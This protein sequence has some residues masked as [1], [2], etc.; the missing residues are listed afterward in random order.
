MQQQQPARDPLLSMVGMHPALAV[1]G[2]TTAVFVL[3]VW[4]AAAADLQVALGIVGATGTVELAT[5]LVVLLFPVAAW[6]ATAG[7][8]VLTSR[9][10]AS[11]RQIDFLLMA[12][13]GAVAITLLVT[14]LGIL[15]AFV[16]FMVLY[17][18]YLWLAAKILERQFHARDV[19]RAAVI[20][21][22]GLAVVVI[23]MPTV[24]LPAENYTVIEQADTPL[25]GYFIEEEG[26]WVTVLQEPDRNLVR[27]RADEIQDRNVC[28]F[29]SPNLLNTP[30]F[31]LLF[32]PA[33]LEQC[34]VSPFEAR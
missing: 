19:R 28:S 6:T 29:V 33:G 18:A 9:Y 24:W 12:T 14:P 23:V 30:I 31:A 20:G 15:L 27:L 16:A 1:A 4:L 22:A 8:A 34:A 7:L 17:P 21:A 10:H 11:G 5:S 2:V 32:R 3:K 26:R 25:V 13:G